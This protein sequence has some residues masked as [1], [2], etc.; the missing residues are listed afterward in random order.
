MIDDPIVAA[1]RKVRR[2]LSEECQHNVSEI[3][4][5]LR[6]REKDAG[7]RLISPHGRSHQ[8]E[9]KSLVSPPAGK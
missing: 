4:S 9:E 8:D 7:S 3:F 1:V 6:K 5:R 2:E